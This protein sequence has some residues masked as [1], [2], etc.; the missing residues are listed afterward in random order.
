MRF[1][2]ARPIRALT[3]KERDGLRKLLFPTE[4][5]EVSTRNRTDDNPDGLRAADTNDKPRKL[6]SWETD[7]A[8]GFFG[9]MIDLDRVRISEN[10]WLT[11][12]GK[13]RGS[14]VTIYNTIYGKDMQKDTLIHELAHVWQYNNVRISPLPAGTTQAVARL[15]GRKDELYDYNV[16]RV[17]DPDRKTFREYS[18]EEQAAIL[19]D[20]F[21][22]TFENRLPKHN[23][24]YKGGLLLPNADLLQLYHLFRWEFEQWH[25]ELQSSRSNSTLVDN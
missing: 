9:D 18:F 2:S 20:A 16:D 12:K 14:G 7:T 10:S 5:R 4:Q 22:V 21:R 23:K 24:D 3:A 17:G 19:Q 13:K 25:E 6:Y 8:E 11:P 1:N 15:I